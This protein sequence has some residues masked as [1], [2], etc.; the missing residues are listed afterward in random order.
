MKHVS[1]NHF[2]VSIECPT[3]VNENS[4]N[5]SLRIANLWLKCDYGIACVEMCSKK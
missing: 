1:K 4:L 5:N 2:W 3:Q